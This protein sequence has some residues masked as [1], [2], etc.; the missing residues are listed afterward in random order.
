MIAA[1]GAPGIRVDLD[2]RA[3]A[4]QVGVSRDAPGPGEL[5]LDVVAARILTSTVDDPPDNPEYR[6][7]ALTGLRAFVGDLPGEIVAVLR[8]AGALT[9]DSRIP[10]QLAALFGWARRRRPRHHRAARLRAAG[11]LGEHADPLPPP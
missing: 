4:A 9:L 3:P 7:S 8:A 1:P 2:R 11:A 10:G 5:M 6:A